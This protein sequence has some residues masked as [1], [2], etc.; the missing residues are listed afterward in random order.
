MTHE[1][2]LSGRVPYLLSRWVSGLHLLGIG[3]L[4]E[5]SGFKVFPPLVLFA[6]VDEHLILKE[7]KHGTEEE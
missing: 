3:E 2:T 1:D 5:Q 4:C 7:I 6:P